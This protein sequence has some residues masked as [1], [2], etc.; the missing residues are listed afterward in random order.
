[1]HLTSDELLGLRR[2]VG[3]TTDAAVLAQAV[4]LRFPG[5]AD[6]V[7][8]A[9]VNELIAD[10]SG[11]GPLHDYVRL[12]EVT[13]VL[14]HGTRGVWIDRGCGLE[15]MPNVWDTEVQVRTFA[16]RL[17][18]AAGVRLDEL[19]PYAD[20]VWDGVRCHIAI[21]PLAHV[22]CVSLRVPQRS[23]RTLSHVLANQP[24]DV[25]T[26]IAGIVHAGAS[27]L[28]SGGTGSGKTTLLTAMLGEVDA[29]KRIVVVEDSAEMDVPHPHTV[30]LR[31][32][33]MSSE[34]VGE[35]GLRV[36]VRQALRMRPDTLVVGEV[37]GGEV[38]DLLAALNTGH[39]GGCTI[40]ANSIAALPARLHS[41]GWMANLPPAAVVTQFAA[42]VH[43]VIH[44]QRYDGVRCV[45]EIHFMVKEQLIPVWSQVSGREAGWNQALELLGSVL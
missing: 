41:L 29:N 44:M 28:I 7:A 33:P 18:T 43:A 22:T 25:S 30:M 5:A 1:M 23:H 42:G 12:P 39:T 19:H 2:S 9:M 8:V 15:M 24:E 26:L 40:H 17:A 36:L 6:D 31:G 37:R 10:A 3:V 11:L 34:G 27:F 32:R 45:H 13:D 4:R 14:V 16:A 21:P 35:M 20:F 38:V